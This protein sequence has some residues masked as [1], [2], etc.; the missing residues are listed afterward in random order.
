MHHIDAV[1]TEFE[2]RLNIV[3]KTLAEID[4]TRN[5]TDIVNSSSNDVDEESDPVAKTKAI[6]TLLLQDLRTSKNLVSLV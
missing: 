5:G 4:S 3:E 2:H 1:Q 6:L